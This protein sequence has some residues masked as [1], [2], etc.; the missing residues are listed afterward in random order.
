MSQVQRD[1]QLLERDRLGRVRAHVLQRER[2][3][4]REAGGRHRG[5]QHRAY[6][7]E[8]VRRSGL[9]PRDIDTRDRD[10]GAV[11]DRRCV[12]RSR[13]RRVE[14][15][16][17]GARQQLLAV[18]AGAVRDV[19]DLGAQR[20]HLLADGG[21][22]AG[23][24]RGVAGLD[25]QFTDA[26]QDVVHLAQRAFSGLE[27]GDAVLGVALALPHATDLGAHLLGDR[28]PGRVISGAVHAHAAG[29]LLE[30]ATQGPVRGA[31]VALRVQRRN[32]GVDL[33]RH[34]RPPV[35]MPR[36]ASLPRGEAARNA[37]PLTAII[38]R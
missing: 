21:T 15:H 13:R 12:V 6:V 5:G 18:E 31:Q 3:G 29:E 17:E 20:Q 30:Q 11:L 16:R 4:P 38:A 24:Q 26:L 9:G 23:G 34:P 10:R 36:V 2:L 32:V 28:E 37:P 25:R 35:P 7:R 22:V 33:Q 8:V 19:V 14:R 27:H 1:A